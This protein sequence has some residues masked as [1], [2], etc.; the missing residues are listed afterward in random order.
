[1]NFNLKSKSELEGTCWI[2]FNISGTVDLYEHWADNSK[3]LDEYAYSF[4]TDIFEE[5][6][7]NF[8]YYGA[9][10]YE[11]EQLERLKQ[12]V[13]DRIKI[14]E[15]LGTIQDII[16]FSKKTSHALNLRQNIEETS[17]KLDGRQHKI[18]VDIKKLGN[19]LSNL[20]DDCIVQNKPLWVLGL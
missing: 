1:M 19:D 10:K 5:N 4:Y 8:N 12:A 9:T 13:G 18:V 20:L 3:Y 14:V 17:G 2:E 7:D 11:K 16:E 6:A 15:R